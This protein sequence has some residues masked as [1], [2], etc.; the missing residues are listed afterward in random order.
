MYP[1]ARDDPCCAGGYSARPDCSGGRAHRCGSWASAGSSSRLAFFCSTRFWRLRFPTRQYRCAHPSLSVWGALRRPPS[2][3]VSARDRPPAWSSPSTRMVEYARS[4]TG[5]VAI[6]EAGSGIMDFSLHPLRRGEGVVEAVWVRWRG[7]LGLCW[8]QMKSE[9]HQTMAIVPN[10]AL[11]KEDAVRLLQRETGQIGLRARLRPGEGAEFNAL[12]EF[13][14]GMDRRMIDWKQS[15]RHAKL[16]VRE[17]QA[18]E[19]LHIIFALDCG[20]LMCEPLEGIPQIDR[21]IQALLLFAFVALRLGDRVGIFAFD[22]K[23]VVRS[24]TIAGVQRVPHAAAACGKARL[25]QRRNQFYTRVDA[26]LCRNVASLD[27]SRVHRLRRQRRSGAD[28]RKCE[29]ASCPSPC[30]VCRVS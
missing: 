13:Q 1:S 14:G 28:G 6:S 25:F 11:V 8:R 21:A 19:N 12:K 27:R 9:V 2:M 29:A 16:L 7:P 4:H 5:Q 23:P 15:A 3:F 24:G 10:I 18:E 26:T 20:R 22:E 30:S 17:F